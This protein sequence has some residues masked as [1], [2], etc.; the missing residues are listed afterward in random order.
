MFLLANIGIG[1]V[2]YL[3][4]IAIFVYIYFGS[5]SLPHIADPFAYAFSFLFSSVTYLLIL[6]ILGALFAIPALALAVIGL[7][8]RTYIALN[9]VTIVLAISILFW[10]VFSLLTGGAWFA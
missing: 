6:G 9:I 3:P 8:S 2:T 1:L 10:N 7:R 4:V 5:L